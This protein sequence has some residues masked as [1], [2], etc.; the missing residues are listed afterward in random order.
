MSARTPFPNEDDDAAVPSA[1]HGSPRPPVTSL[2]PGVSR[3]RVSLRL[4]DSARVE[5]ARRRFHL[6]GNAADGAIGTRPGDLVAAGRRRSRRLWIPAVLLSADAAA[7]AVAMVLTSSPSWKLLAVLTLILALFQTAALYRPR[8]SLSVL[9]DAP[10]IVGR[11]LAAGAAAMVL[12]GL[13]D[14]VAGTA[15]LATSAVFGVFC[16]VTRVVAYCGIRGARRR[17][18]LQQ[19]TLLLGAGT[20]AGS[21]A[22]NLVAHR[23]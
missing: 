23:E 21:L 1:A 16:V 22:T 9:D 17:G 2:G 5:Q 12:G 11:A 19:R 6:T 8:L 13:D 20:L 10:A 3:P 15:R 14:G 7:F 18:R 4:A